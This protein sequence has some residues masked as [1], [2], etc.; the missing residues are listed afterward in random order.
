MLQI[1]DNVNND[2]TS[3]E[4]FP[5]DKDVLI[6]FYKDSLNIANTI[7]YANRLREQREQRRIAEEQAAQRKAETEA[8][9]AA[10]QKPQAG[11]IPFFESA[12]QPAA[13][14]AVIE[15]VEFEEIPKIGTALLTRAFR[16]VTTREN[17]IALGNFMNERGINFEK[18]EPEKK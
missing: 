5:E 1:L 9:K 13:P 15:D 4:S 10:A 8:Q 12:K 11:A 6:T 14:A 2:I 3:L 18:I 17:I 16:V 7:Q